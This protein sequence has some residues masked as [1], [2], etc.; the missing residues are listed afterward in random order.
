MSSLRYCLY[1]LRSTYT[2]RFMLLT[3]NVLPYCS[4]FWLIQWYSNP[5][6]LHTVSATVLGCSVLL[7]VMKRNHPDD[8]VDPTTRTGISIIAIIIWSTLPCTIL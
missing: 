2:V 8:Q 6:I 3:S 1:V 4:I 7:Y 5:V